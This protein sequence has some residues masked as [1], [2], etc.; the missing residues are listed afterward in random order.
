MKLQQLIERYIS[1]RQSLGT[2]FSTNAIILRAFCRVIGVRVA[3]TNVDAKRVRAFLDGTGPVTSAWHIRHNALLGFYRYAISRGYVARSPLPTELPKQPPRFVPYVYTRE[4][5]LRLLRATD[6]Y[7]RLR[8]G[9]EPATMRTILLLLYATGVR[10]SEA[11]ALNHSDL[12]LEACV[13]TVR[14]TKFYKTR[15]VPFGTQLK[16]VLAQHMGRCP[17]TTG[18][19][20]STPL[21]PSRT[22]KRITRSWLEKCFR[23]LREHAGI[24]RFDGASYQPRLHDLRHTFAVH[25]LTSWYREG[26]DVQN[27]LP[28]LSVYLGHVN[29]AATQVY[30]SMTPELLAQAGARFERFA[31]LEGNHD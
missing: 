11:L 18:G 2:R 14:L 5:L 31:G 15:L 24:R 19:V 21:F 4:E 26:A 10:V 6:S 23:R 13:L 8:V 28:Y 3:I 20:G 1:Y 7:Q 25:R 9:I 27:L 22:S 12:D 30:L 17:A 16:H 29:L